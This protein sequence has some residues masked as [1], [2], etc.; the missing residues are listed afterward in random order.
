MFLALLFLKVDIEGKS[1]VNSCSETAHSKPK[2]KMVITD[3]CNIDE[4]KKNRL[5]KSGTEQDTPF[6]LYDD[7][8][9][10]KVA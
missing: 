9:Q 6:H 8:E 3:T 1:I 7:Q 10:A 5:K 2:G 4:Y